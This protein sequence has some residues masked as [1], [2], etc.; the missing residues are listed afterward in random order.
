[1]TDADQHAAGRVRRCDRGDAEAAQ[2]LAAVQKDQQTGSV[3]PEKTDR[4]ARR[5]RDW[6][7]EAASARWLAGSRAA[8]HALVAGSEDSEEWGT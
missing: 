5:V 7:G 3:V 6:P 8:R 4:A 1:M 2:L